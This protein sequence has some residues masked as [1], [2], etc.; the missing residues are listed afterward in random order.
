MAGVNAELVGGGAELVDEGGGL[1]AGV[2]A[3]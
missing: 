2:G 1:S 3:E